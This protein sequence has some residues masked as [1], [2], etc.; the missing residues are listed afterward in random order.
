LPAK[1]S[2][3]LPFCATGCCKNPAWS[4]VIRQAK[5]WQNS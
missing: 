5:D 1:A 3:V 2:A 4:R